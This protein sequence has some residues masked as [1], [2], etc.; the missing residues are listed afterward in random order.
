MQR[1]QFLALI[2]TLRAVNRKLKQVERI[3]AEVPQGNIGSS[4]ASTRSPGKRA[5]A[6]RIALTGCSGPHLLDRK[7]PLS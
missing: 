5:V 1:P 3:L 4:A 7:T 2:R 6:V